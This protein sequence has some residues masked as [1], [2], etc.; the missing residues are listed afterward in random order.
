M[1]ISEYIVGFIKELGVKYVF[2]LQG[3]G[4]AVQMID[5]LGETEGIDYVCTLHEQ[6]AGMAADAYAQVT[7]NIGV[8]V[9]TCGPGATNLMTC[10]AGSFYNSNPVVYIIGQPSIRLLLK[11][12]G[13]RHYAYHEN[14]LNIFKPITKYVVQISDPENVRYEVEKAFYIAKEGRPGPVVIAIPD[15]ITWLQI[16]P[17]EQKSFNVEKKEN[18]VKEDEIEEVFSLIGQAKRPVLLLG[19]GVKCAK[20]QELAFRLIEKLKWPVLLTWGA[21]DLL[22]YDNKQNVGSFGIQGTRAGNFT[23][24]NADFILSIGSRLD[25]SETGLPQKNFARGA[26]I[27]S[28]DIDNSE[29]KKYNRYGLNVYKAIYCDAKAFMSLFIEKF[30]DRLISK[31]SIF[32]WNNKVNYWKSK[33][34]VFNSSYREEQNVNPYVFFEELAKAS[35]VNSVIVTDSST[36]RNYCFQSFKNKEGQKL[37]TWWNFA[38]LGY[39]LPAAIGA[40]FS[41]NDT[42]IAIMGDGALQFNIQE[43]ATIVYNKLNLKIFVFDNGGYA[44]IQHTQNR[45]IGRNHGTDRATGLPLPDSEKIA[46]AYGIPVFK[47]DSNAGMYDKL[48]QV[49]NK[50]GP[51]YCSV[52]LPINHWTVPCRVGN[53][54]IEDMTPKLDRKE[55][56]EQMIVK[57]LDKED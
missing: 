29:V 6:A 31:Q 49:I 24:Q 13:L 4:T 16:E 14:D 54:P 33:Y 26:K 35:G 36:S 3:S 42:V 23:V 21:K 51:V 8:C 34:P 32:E 19:K 39:C 2:G 48:L 30:D 10:I 53:D 38:C 43:L 15:D 22:A 41:T 7:G 1:K 40:C 44:N 56:Y 9:T 55:F 12:E 37:L 18:F 52:V 11:V 47:I 46:E 20:A 50:E 45:F 5:A 28:I 25:P 17:N 27:V 57:P